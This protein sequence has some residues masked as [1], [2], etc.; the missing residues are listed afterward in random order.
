MAF[1]Y[2]SAYGAGTI[3]LLLGL[4]LLDGTIHDQARVFAGILCTSPYWI[5][6]FRLLSGSIAKED[7]IKNCEHDFHGRT[8]GYGSNEKLCFLCKKCGLVT[9]E[10]TTKGE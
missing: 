7:R 9:G 2:K 1:L 8:T 6:C 5:H 3:L 10:S 4:V